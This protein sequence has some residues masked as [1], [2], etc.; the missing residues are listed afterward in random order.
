VANVETW[1]SYVKTK[2]GRT[3]MIY[4]S[5]GFWPSIGNPDL[6]A[7]VLWVAHWGTTCPTMPAGWASWSFHQDSDSGTVSGISGGV[8]TDVFDGDQAALN[9]I[10][11]NGKPPVV[12]GGA[13]PDLAGAPNPDLAESPGDLADVPAT[14]GNGD[15]GG[16]GDDP[17]AA[18]AKG[19]SMAAHGELP[20]PLAVLA[21]ALVL[22]QLKRRDQKCQKRRR[23]ARGPA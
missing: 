18:M 12:D 5:P 16:K 8:D 2:T 17:G 6:S 13:P 23:P 22:C 15:T 14:G 7:Y 4:T 3:P 20:A 9:A 1:L 21:I 19:C 11:S 10:A